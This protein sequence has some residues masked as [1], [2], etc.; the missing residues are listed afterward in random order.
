MDWFI[1]Y[2]ESVV[3]MGFILFCLLE[4]IGLFVGR[5]RDEA[6]EPIRRGL[7]RTVVMLTLIFIYLKLCS[8]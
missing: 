1:K 8:T 2:T 6:L 3:Y 5:E 4:V 7:Y